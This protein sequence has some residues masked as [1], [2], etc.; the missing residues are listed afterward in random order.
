MKMIENMLSRKKSIWESYQDKKCENKIDD[1]KENVQ[2]LKLLLNDDAT[3]NLQKKQMIN[4][5]KSNI[6]RERRPKL[7][8]VLCAF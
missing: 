1:L 6:I 4:R 8:Y 2:F 5:C 3:H 7:R